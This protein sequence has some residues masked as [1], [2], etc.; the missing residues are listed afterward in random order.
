[1][2]R[3]ESLPTNVAAS[4]DRMHPMTHVFVDGGECPVAAVV[5]RQLQGFVEALAVIVAELAMI[6]PTGMDRM[7]VSMWCDGYTRCLPHRVSS[8]SLDVVTV[9][10]LD[11][12]AAADALP[13]SKSHAALPEAWREA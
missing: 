5:I 7:L 2:P 8:S 3:K 11:R 6:L 9:G 4:H 12:S 13:S 10:G 1:M